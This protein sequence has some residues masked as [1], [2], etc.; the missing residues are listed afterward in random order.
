MSGVV[1]D[2]KYFEYG[3]K[4]STSS[5]GNQESYFDGCKT[6]RALVEFAKPD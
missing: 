1:I 5:Y 2:I 6:I 4:F 3:C